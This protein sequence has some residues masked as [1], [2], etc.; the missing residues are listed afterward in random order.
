MDDGGASSKDAT[1][2]TLETLSTQPP[3]QMVHVEQSGLSSSSKSSSMEF[4]H[5]IC[6]N[7]VSHARLANK[8]KFELR[9]TGRTQRCRTLLFVVPLVGPASFVAVGR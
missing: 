9:S 6:V 1:T 2:A 4:P 3:R 8:M 7:L 5:D